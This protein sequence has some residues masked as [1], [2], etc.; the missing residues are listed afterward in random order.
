M[1]IDYRIELKYLDTEGS[2]RDCQIYI[3]SLSLKP[4]SFSL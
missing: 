4:L 3:F 1:D 2:E